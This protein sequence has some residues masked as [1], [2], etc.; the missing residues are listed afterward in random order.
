MPNFD[1]TFTI[2]SRRSHLRSQFL[3]R[4]YRPQPWPPPVQALE[5]RRNQDATTPHGRPISRS[6]ASHEPS[7]RHAHL[8]WPQ[9]PEAWTRIK[10]HLRAFQRWKVKVLGFCVKARPRPQRMALDGIVP[11]SPSS[12]QSARR[13]VKLRVC[14][15][16]APPPCVGGVSPVIL[17]IVIVLRA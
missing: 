9:L 5:I 2:P 10:A 8:P 7:E 4:K 14:R 11:H 1:M 16:P 15:F 12:A 3:H 13:A 6:A 17:R